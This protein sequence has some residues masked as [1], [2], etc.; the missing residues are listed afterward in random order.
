MRKYLL[1]LCFILLFALMIA[2]I[3]QQ[4]DVIIP[5]PKP[6]PEAQINANQPIKEQE[7][8]IPQIVQYPLEISAEVRELLDKSKIRVKSIHYRYRAPETGNNFHEFYV[9]GDKIKYKPAREIQAL[10]QKESYDFI[11]LDKTAKTAVSYCEAPYCAYKGRKGDLNYAEV[12]IPTVFDWID[13]LTKAN[14]IGEELIDDRN[15][16]KV[17]TNNGILWIDTFYGIPLKVEFNGKIYRFQLISV[18]T[19]QD[20]DVTVV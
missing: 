17:E 14:K 20:A 11:Y 9:K 2:C 10:D 18:N 7:V 6:K 1:A 8:V 16:W 15:N 12:Y 5:A 3:P 19:V 13:G 4:K